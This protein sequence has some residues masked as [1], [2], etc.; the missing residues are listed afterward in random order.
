MVATEIQPAYIEIGHQPNK[1][2]F[3][4][5]RHLSIFV[6]MTILMSENKITNIT[7]TDNHV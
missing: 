7:T 1:I 6:L 5:A 2:V 4:G 3:A